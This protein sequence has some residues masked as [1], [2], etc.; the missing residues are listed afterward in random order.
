MRSFAPVVGRAPRVLVL[1]S[2]P[3]VASLAAGEYYA[4]RQN[5]FWKIL[6]DLDVVPADLPYS[7]RI[8]GLRRARIALWDVLA[9]CERR[10]SLDAAIVAESEVPNDIA[11]L[12]A[13]HPSLGAVLFNGTKAE[14][15]FRRRVLP[16]LDGAASRRLV[17]LRLPSTSP[18]RA[19]PY[20]EKLTAWRQAL[21]AF[22]IK[23]LR[24]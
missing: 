7:R 18:A 19:I 13:G 11:G 21:N 14:E 15:T 2:I 16:L 8:A 1:G 5:A 17:F 22:G 24:R 20:A 6:S 12:I 10:G 9:S 23:R 3:S 4:H